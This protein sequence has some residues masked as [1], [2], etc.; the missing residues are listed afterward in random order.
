MKRA[1]KT[2]A[3]IV[4]M[5]LILPDAALAGADQYRLVGE[6]RQDYLECEVPSDDVRLSWASAFIDTT[7]G[8]VGIEREGEIDGQALYEGEEIMSLVEWT[9]PVLDPN[10][11]K[12]VVFL[13]ASDMDRPTSLRVRAE[14]YRPGRGGFGSGYQ[15]FASKV[16]QN[17]VSAGAYVSS[18]VDQ[19]Y[20]A[21]DLHI[22]IS[23]GGP[24]TDNSV[25]VYHFERVD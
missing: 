9:R 5:G 22:S 8:P 12:L 1:L 23:D 3:P 11:N 15:V 6:T 14:L 17:A 10:R 18:I 25:V 24:C 19:G 7:S 4:A 13:A 16:T 2:L 21:F 20:P